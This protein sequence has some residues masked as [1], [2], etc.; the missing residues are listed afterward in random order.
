MAEEIKKEEQKKK[1]CE[2]KSSSDDKKL[3]GE[4]DRLRALG[5]NPVPK[6]NFATTHDAW[7]KHYGRMFSTPAYY[8][9][10]RELIDEVSE[11]FDTP[12]YFHI[13]MDE[14]FPSTI[15][16]QRAYGITQMRQGEAY[17]RDMDFLLECCNA[18]KTRAWTWLDIAWFHRDDVFKYLSKEYLV[19]NAMYERLLN[20]EVYFDH[21]AVEAYFDLAKH[22]YEQ[23]PTC[24][25]YMNSLNQIDAVDILGNIDGLKGF[26]TAPWFRT[27][28]IDKLKLMAEAKCF[29][30]AKNRFDNIGK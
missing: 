26:I 30:F 14:E 22:G 5:L 23:V 28:E 8:K 27:R 2:K 6:L 10:V 18:N 20:F 24:A 13:G 9:A 11:L 16:Y 21:P 1:T 29:G 17:W 15:G 12:D 19:S 4:L 7:F 3:K 25:T